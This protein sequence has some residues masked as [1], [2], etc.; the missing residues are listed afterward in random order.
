MYFLAIIIFKIIDVIKLL[1]T[2]RIICSWIFPRM[3]NTFSNTVYSLTE[4]ILSR[5]R[6]ILPISNIGIDISPII[7]YAFFSLVKRVI[8]MLIYI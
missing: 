6:F 2:I 4:P 5:F 8:V 1:I 7:A 3:D